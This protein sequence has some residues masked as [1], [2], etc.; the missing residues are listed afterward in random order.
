M[1]YGL[2]VMPASRS[3]C[4]AP[5]VTFCVETIISVTGDPC[6]VPESGCMMPSLGPTYVEN[7]ADMAGPSGPGG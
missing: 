2:W 7:K 1:V 3:D 4:P 5:M 6:G